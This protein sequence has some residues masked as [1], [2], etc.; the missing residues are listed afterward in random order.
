MLKMLAH[1]L[2]EVPDQELIRQSVVEAFCAKAGIAGA[3]LPAL[4]KKSATIPA[5]SLLFN[6]DQKAPLIDKSQTDALLQV[7]V[8]V[9][10]ESRGYYGGEP[11]VARFERDLDRRNLLHNF[12]DKFQEIAGVP[13]EQG[14]EEGILSEQAV[15]QAWAEITD[16]QTTENILARYESQFTFDRGF[17]RGAEC[18]KSRS[19]TTAAF[20][21]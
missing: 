10:N 9:F 7:F 13:W 16:G 11:S 17:R 12:K 5:T 15:T 4:I 1:L 18:L 19:Q 20:P 14:R 6:I 21:G 2:G 3:M 8:K